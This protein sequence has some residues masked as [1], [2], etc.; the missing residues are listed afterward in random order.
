MDTS[1]SCLDLAEAEFSSSSPL[2]PIVIET[3]KPSEQERQLAS[4][5][6]LAYFTKK[7]YSEALAWLENLFVLRP[8]DPRV[9]GNLALVNFLVEGGGF[10]ELAKMQNNLKNM[11]MNL[12]TGESCF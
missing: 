11:Y 6:S 5:A 3:Q 4:K 1:L 10:N 12:L 7:N 9:C 2:P 8:N